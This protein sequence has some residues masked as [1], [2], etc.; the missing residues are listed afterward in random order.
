MFQSF[1]RKLSA[2]S[3]LQHPRNNPITFFSTTPSAIVAPSLLAC[4]LSK[5]AEEAKQI[6]NAGADQLH[7]DVMDGHFVP[8]LT[9]GPPV[10]KCLRTH[11]TAFLDCHVMVTNPEDYVEDMAD[12]GADSFVFHIESTKDPMNMIQLIRNAKRK[13]QVGIAINPETSVE[14]IFPYADMCDILLVMTVKPGFGGQ[15]FMH[16]MLP[17]VAVLREKFPDKDIQVDGGVGLDSIEAAANA[18]ANM[19]VGGSSIFGADDKA[20]VIASMRETLNVA[21]AARL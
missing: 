7:I 12:A 4:D 17:K 16:E 1:S 13:M 19:V 8:N 15:S 3:I 21:A 11:T 2:S 9:W 5:M 6:V 20:G 14:T 10:L 18:G